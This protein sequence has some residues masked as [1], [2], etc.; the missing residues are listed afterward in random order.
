MNYVNSDYAP[1]RATIVQS[2]MSRPAW[3]YVTM[4]SVD[5]EGRRENPERAFVAA[6][7]LDGIRAAQR[8]D[9]AAAAWLDEFGPRLSEL[10][11]FEIADWRRG[12]GCSFALCEAGRTWPASTSN[13]GRT[14]S[15]QG[16]TFAELI[17]SHPGD[18]RAVA[19]VPSTGSAGAPRG[20]APT[21]GISR[22][23]RGDR[24]S[25]RG[26]APSQGIGVAV[27][28]PPGAPARHMRQFCR[29]S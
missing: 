18:Q 11:G 19:G 2:P 23:H 20:S 28:V 6:W 22:I 17:G 26:S 13:L 12:G 24:P 8:G 14:Q 29:A 3:Y 9:S 4:Q 15:T 5:S 1:V 7:L 16:R 25:P 27:C 21:R 10:I